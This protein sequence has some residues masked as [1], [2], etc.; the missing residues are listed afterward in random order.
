[1]LLLLLLMPRI[2]LHV[3]PLWLRLLVLRLLHLLR[4]LGQRMQ[5]LS[6]LLLPQL[7][8]LFLLLL[9]PPPLRM[10]LLERESEG[11]SERANESV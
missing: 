8:L 5:L 3:L 10:H 2:V 4:L 7:W 11:A 6:L 1:M 9:P